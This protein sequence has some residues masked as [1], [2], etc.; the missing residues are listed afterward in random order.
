MAAL[1]KLKKKAYNNYINDASEGRLRLDF[2]RLCEMH[3]KESPQ[4]FYWNLVMSMEL[5]TL[6]LIQS[7]RKADFELYHK[8]LAELLPYFF[9]NNNVNYA[10]WLTIH[11]RD[12]MAIEENHP[13][14]AEELEKGNFVVHKSERAFS[15]LAIDQAHEQNNAVIKGI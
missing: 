3:K 9:A 14:I 2:E 7:F 4:F 13:N 15:G 11:L 6:T 5:A 8:S 12:M 10:R 1:Y